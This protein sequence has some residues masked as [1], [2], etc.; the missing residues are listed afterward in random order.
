MEYLEIISP[1]DFGTEDAEGTC[2]VPQP[3]LW[4]HVERSPKK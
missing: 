2:D 1:A 4:A 3:T